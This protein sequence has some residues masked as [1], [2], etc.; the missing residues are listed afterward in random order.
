VTVP[1]T[2]GLPPRRIDQQRSFAP[3]GVQP[4]AANV[5]RARLVIVS[6]TNGGIFV[7]NGTAGLG[8][9]VISLAPPGVTADPYGNTVTPD[10]LAVYGAA[11]QEIFLGLLG[12]VAELQFR[13]GASIEATPANIASETISAGA[14]ETLEMLL[15]GPKINVAGSEDWVQLLLASNNP[16]GTQN[17]QFFINWIST[18]GTVN[19]VAAFGET[20]LALFNVVSVPLAFSNLAGLFAVN[21]N[22][23]FMGGADGNVYDT[24]RLTQMLQGT[25]TTT[26]TSP[27]VPTAG[28]VS[29]SAAV[30]AAAYRWKAHV[31]YT[32]GQNAGTLAWAF[33]GPAATFGRVQFTNQLIAGG[34]ITW[35]AGNSFTAYT[36]AFDSSTLSTTNPQV[37]DA[38]GQAVFSASGTLSLTVAEVIN[39][40]TGVI[41]AGSWLEVFPI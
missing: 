16:G 11:G 17:A 36:T 28:I 38:E 15:S 14:T 6:G 33:S 34:N 40:D 4:G 30:A 27:A 13:T 7:Y 35:T 8:T 31:I 23:K 19:E 21:G 25:Y 41:G 9:L 20:G 24:G 39:G 32:G 3:P 26:S 37:L 2:G 29:L 12:T 5:V 10:G 1:G 22:L 18:A